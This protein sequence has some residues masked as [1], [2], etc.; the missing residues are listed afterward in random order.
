MG[1][2]V[3]LNHYTDY[4]KSKELEET[5]DTYQTLLWKKLEELD[6]DPSE[7]SKDHVRHK[8]KQKADELGLDEWGADILYHTRV[9]LDSEKYPDHMFKIGYFRSSYNDGGI[10]SVLRSLDIPDLNYIFEAG[11]EYEFCPDWNQA[12]DR[13]KSV[14]EMYKKDKGYR[15]ESVSANLFN[16]DQ[17][18]KNPAAAMDIFQQQFF[19]SARTFTSY[20]NR[21]G[22]FYLDKKGLQ[23]H[24]LIPGKDFMDRPCTYAIYK[25][26][27]SVK[28]YRQSLEI[29]LETIEYVLK[30]KDPQNYYLRWSG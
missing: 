15:V 25:N 13:I 16:P 3:Y 14:L 7:K 29:V 30:Q 1:L 5:Y 21:D 10:N 12:L 4:K 2:D 11:D 24:A 23:V 20:S 9:E 19:S 6:P 8:C 28:H 26:E 27:A 17:V 18:A 22:A